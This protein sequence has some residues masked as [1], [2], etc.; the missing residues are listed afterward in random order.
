[1]LKILCPDFF[2]DL[3]RVI[4][5]SFSPEP[6]V[7]ILD[8]VIDAKGW[9]KDQTPALHDHLKAHQFKFIRNDKGHCR[10]YYKEWSTDDY[11]L[12]QTGLAILPTESPSLT[13]KPNIM[14]PCFDT[15]N[16]KKLES[17][18]QIKARCI[19]EQSWCK[20]MVDAVVV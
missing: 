8:S 13:A 6:K 1:M 3:S 10:M 19:H 4:Q 2:P 16:L 14:M 5:S 9:M 18:L 17:T 20:S 15:D 7:V 11:W 12:P